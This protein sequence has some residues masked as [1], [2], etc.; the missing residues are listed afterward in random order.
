MKARLLILIVGL[1]ICANAQNPSTQKEA[2]Q[3][4]PQLADPG[5]AFNQRF[6]ARVK[7]LR[8]GADP[9]LQS[10]DWPLAVA[11]QIASELGVTAAT[12]AKQGDAEAQFNLGWSYA[13]GQGVPKDKAEAVKWFRKAALQG[14]AKA[15]FYL[16]SSYLQGEGVQKDEAAAV[17]WYRKAAEQGYAEAQFYLGSMYREGLGVPKDDAQAYKWFL[18]AGAQGQYE[19]QTRSGNLEVDSK[20]SPEQRAA[21]LRM[22]HEFKPKQSPPADGTV[23]R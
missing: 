1:T 2:L 18:L 10:D 3:L 21:G 9:L 8:A 23:P 16:G 6:V 20:V 22:A 12:P 7:S 17:T 5:S 13:N 15:Q 4:Y 19:A 14:S 11:R